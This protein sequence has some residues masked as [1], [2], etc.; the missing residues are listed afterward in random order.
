MY[1]IR[2]INPDATTGNLQTAD[3]AMVTT[4]SIDMAVTYAVHLSDIMTDDTTF[5]VMLKTDTVF[6][7]AVGVARKGIWVDLTTDKENN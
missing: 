2:Y 6:D 1:N 3:G 5:V 7:L 4:N